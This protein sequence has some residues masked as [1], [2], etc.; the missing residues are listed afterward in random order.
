MSEKKKDLKTELDTAFK[1][2][3]ALAVSGDTVDVIAVSGDTVDVIAAVR[4]HLRAAY[5]LA[6]DRSAV[7]ELYKSLERQ[8]K[9][10]GSNG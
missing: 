6:E 10:E 5:R 7:W 1:L 4:E 2:I 9:K 3:S 8:E